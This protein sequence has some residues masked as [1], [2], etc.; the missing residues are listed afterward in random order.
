MGSSR[1]EQEPTRVKKPSAKAR[2]QRDDR[3]YAEFDA[4]MRRLAKAS[5]RDIDAARAK[6]DRTEQTGPSA[7]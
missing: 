1:A 2:R 4:V 6:S 7:A 3:V 5:K